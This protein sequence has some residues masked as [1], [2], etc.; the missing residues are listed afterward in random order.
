VAGS[1]LAAAQCSCALAI[2]V[3]HVLHKHH[4]LKHWMSITWAFHHEFPVSQ[5]NNKT[6]KADKT[7]LWH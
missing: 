1:V 7:R 5:V 6:A 4:Y 3:H 2:A